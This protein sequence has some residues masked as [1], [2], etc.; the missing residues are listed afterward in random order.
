MLANAEEEEMAE[1]NEA[2][3]TYLDEHGPESF[4]LQL[5]SEVRAH[6]HHRALHHNARR[7]TCSTDHRPHR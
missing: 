6:I 1:S 3:A 2:L 7:P 5:G 4:V